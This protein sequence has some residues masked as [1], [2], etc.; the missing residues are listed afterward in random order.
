MFRRDKRDREQWEE[1]RGAKI[2]GRKR[3]GGIWV[4]TINMNHQ[5]NPT[6]DPSVVVQH[7]ER[8][9]SVVDTTLILGKELS[10]A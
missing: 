10:H 5:Q 7:P 3:K 1:Y 6:V 8:I 2:G 9:H 4:K